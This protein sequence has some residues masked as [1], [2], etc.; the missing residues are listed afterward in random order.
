LID[1]QKSIIS[2]VMN[3]MSSNSKSY[4]LIRVAESTA[5]ADDGPTPPSDNS[6]DVE[7]SY[8][9]IDSSTHPLNTNM[10][11]HDD[12][13]FQENHV[14][15]RVLKDIQLTLGLF[16]KQSLFFLISLLVISTISLITFVLVLSKPINPATTSI[17]SISMKT[18]FHANKIAFGSCTSY[19]LREMTIWND[20]IIPS[21]PDVWIWTGD[22]AYLDDSEVNCRIY[23]DSEDWQ[24]NCNCSATWLSHPPF[25]CHGGDVNYA[26]DRWIKT[27]SDGPYNDFL[28]YMCPKTI[29]TGLFPPEG[30]NPNICHRGIFGIYDDH[31]FGANDANGREL[32]K[33][34]YKN[35]YLDAIGESQSSP[36]RGQDRGAWFKYTLNQGIPHKEVDIIL[37]DERYERQS[38][39]CENRREYC[40]KLVLSGQSVTAVS[41][42]RKAWCQDFLKTGGPLNQGSCCSKDE[43]LYFG[44]CQ[45]P[46]S[47]SHPYYREV[48]D[49]TFDKFGMRSFVL[50]RS[51][52]NG[53]VVDIRLPKADDPVDTFKE[54][55]FCEVLGKSQRRWLRKVVKESTAAVKIFVS[56][57]VLF[58]NPLFRPCGS[59]RN[60]TTGDIEEAQCRCSGDNM[61]CFHVAQLELSHLIASVSR[62]AIVITGDYHFSDIKA[63]HH[64]QI[65]KPYVSYYHALNNSQAIY[66]VMSSGMSESTAI[67]YTCEDFRRD[68]M[69]LRTHPECSFVIGPNFGRIV[70]DYDEKQQ[71]LNHIKLQVLSGQEKEK[72]LLE[73]IIDPNTCNK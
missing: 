65:H 68:P 36:R 38:I 23:S 15:A 54:S 50:E 6:K 55:P 19:D 69:H 53:S 67:H 9:T 12:E 47:H 58:D 70:L 8:D 62:C 39:P 5:S 24:R 42:S 25:A 48:C 7:T 10:S 18:S 63:L 49:V 30:S 60:K 28:E 51:A 41:E 46:S 59:Y 21:E 57:S 71:K 13:Q 64:D 1:Q 3:P 27:L 11:G 29:E 52:E 4:E 61:D 16:S 43:D 44:W 45:L 56:G 66:Q 31:D 35:M 73:T 20:A 17:D 32:S 26:R 34:E 37:L 14:S 22:M 40:E 72:V 2:A 33:H